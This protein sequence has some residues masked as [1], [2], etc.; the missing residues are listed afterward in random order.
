MTVK[1]GF[2]N[3]ERN[4]KSLRITK[5][6]TAAEAHKQPTG[7]VANVVLVKNDPSILNPEY[8]SWNF[9]ITKKRTTP[10]SRYALAKTYE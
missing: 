5:L 1:I 4:L 9:G 3:R 7:P 2:K 10:Q 6:P 8:I